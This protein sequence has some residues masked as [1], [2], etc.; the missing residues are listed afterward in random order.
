M[1]NISKAVIDKIG[2]LLALA[3]GKGTTTNEAANAAAAAQELMDRHKLT[4]AIVD[5]RS[6]DDEDVSAFPRDPLMTG[7]LD[8][9][10]WRLR[11]ADSLARMNDCCMLMRTGAKAEQGQAWLVGR[12]SDVLVTR[13]L[14]I[15]LA[16]EISRI[17]YAEI[18][19]SAHN[20]EQ[21]HD[22]FC[23]GAAA[24][25]FHRLK[26]SRKAVQREAL[27]NKGG[28]AAL[29]LLRDRSKA[30][31]VFVKQL[32]QGRSLKFG[33]EAIDLGAHLAGRR[34]GQTIPIHTA[35]T[36]GDAAQPR[37]LPDHRKLK[38]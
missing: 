19:K 11:L 10:R 13:Y 8:L 14:Y 15:Y 28:E 35:V 38:T 7:S 27:S 5:A 29:V 3:E 6:L 34:A 4:R 22:N 24:V 33:D 25:V 26:E 37:A 12:E 23:N 2:K 32:T 16:R 31:E 9:F 1:N 17:A 18:D 20:P 30:V 21:W 36:A